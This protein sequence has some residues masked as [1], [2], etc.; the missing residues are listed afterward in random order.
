M[1]VR[2]DKKS[3]TKKVLPLLSAEDIEEIM[4]QI[5][6]VPLETPILEMTIAQ[7]SAVVDDESTFIE[8]ILTKEKYL[9]NALGRLKSY[10]RQMNELTNFFKLYDIKQTKEEKQAAV[11]VV[12]PDMLS[13]MLLTVTKFFGLKS[14]DEAEKVKLSAYLMIF[15]DESSSALY[16]RNYNNI[17]NQQM[18]QKQKK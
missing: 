5:D 3:K 7:F 9:F 11:G 17:I 6:E 4:K 12:F 2:L 10:K 1:L 14:F 15:Q 16:Q 8:D 18:K 13:K